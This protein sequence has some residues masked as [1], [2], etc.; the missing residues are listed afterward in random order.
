MRVEQNVDGAGDALRDVSGVRTHSGTGQVVG[1]LTA[2]GCVVDVGGSPVGV[3][4][5]GVDQAR[6]LGDL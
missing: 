2:C 4:V 6:G 1:I 5:G 3:Q